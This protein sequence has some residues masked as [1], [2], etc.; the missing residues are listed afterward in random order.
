MK[1]IIEINNL[2]YKYPGEKDFV[3][4]NINLNIKKNSFSVIIGPSGCGKTTLL[5]LIRGFF[6]E[7]GGDIKGKISVLKK[8]IKKTDISRLGKN[9]GIIF[10]DP[11]T[12]LH[13]LRVIDEVAS[14]PMYQGVKYEKCINKAKKLIDKILGKNFYY[15]SPNELSSGQQQK[16]A[17]AAVLAMECEILLLDEPFSFLD[18]KAKNEIL[19]FLNELK[20][21]GKTILL[22]THDIENISGKADELVLINKGK[23]IKKDTLKQ[24]LYY[25]D[26]D[27]VLELPLSIKASKKLK[28]KN[29]PVNWTEVLKNK[30]F[31]TKLKSSELKKNKKIILKLEN[32]NFHYPNSSNGV[33][34]INLK[35]YKNEVLGLIGSNGSG[36]T[37]LAKI[38]LGFLKP[39]KG[40]VILNN[41][42]IKKLNTKQK[43]KKIGYVTQDPIDMFFEESLIKEVSF[44]PKCLE[45]NNPEKIAEKTLEKLSLI[46]YKDKHPD[47]LSGGEKSL[48]GI[49]DIL[50][51]DPEI[52][53]LDEPEFGLDPRNWHKIVNIIKEL[54]KQGKT[55][56]VI[57]QDLEKSMFLC[58]RIALMHKGEIIKT[59][60]PKQVFRKDI[61][62]KTNLL[63]LP[64]FKILQYVSDDSLKSEEKFIKE[65]VK[66][67]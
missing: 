49:A 44:G 39:N 14:A 56:I 52:L 62:N 13:Q 63:S 3:L 27:K 51:N 53:L 58:D 23:I 29:K 61:L 12:Q 24:L 1:N 38:I 54:Q 32:I 67:W 59:G 22:A 7:F 31:K 4:K 47:S 26:F 9:I 30:K 42:N 40:K 45:L 15:K 36:K 18:T 5:M 34:N 55:I 50:A 65:V 35:L 20:N 64:V 48:L 21:L 41:E 37:T 25:Q 8:N 11:A 43:A 10:Q 2:S 16:V 33:E 60:T 6:H 28:I 17:L 57:T 46:K 66:I 19:E